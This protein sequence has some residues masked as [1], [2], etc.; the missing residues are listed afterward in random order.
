MTAASPLERV[1][2]CALSD[3]L[4]PPECWLPEV[5]AMPAVANAAGVI[6]VLEVA[7]AVRASAAIAALVPAAD[8]GVTV[9]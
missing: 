5:E 7:D 2:E 3:P 4:K 6:G 8:D 9:V 1:R